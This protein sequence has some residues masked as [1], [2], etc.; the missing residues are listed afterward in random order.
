MKIT[1]TN[2]STKENGSAR[3]QRAVSGILAGHTVRARRSIRAIVH[4]VP[5]DG[6]R[7]MRRPARWKRALPFR[8]EIRAPVVD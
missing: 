2:Q 4:P 5:P 7:R 6:L 1:E 8:W 3:F